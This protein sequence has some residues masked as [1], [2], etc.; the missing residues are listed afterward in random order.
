KKKI[1]IFKI[2]SKLIKDVL[3]DMMLICQDINKNKMLNE[4]HNK[5]GIIVIMRPKKNS[6][7][8]PEN[9]NSKSTIEN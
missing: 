6:T 7:L 3:D 8:C 2:P 4:N 1:K 9:F 5:K